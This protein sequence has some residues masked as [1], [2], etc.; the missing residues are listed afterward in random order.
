MSSVFS[1]NSNNYNLLTKTTIPITSLNTGIIY[2]GSYYLIGGN[3]VTYS[4]NSTT[5]ASTPISIS[6]MTSIRNFAWN[7]PSCGIPKIQPLTIACG[8]G[9]NTL[10]YSPDGIYWNGLGKHIFTTRSNKAI[11]NGILWTAVGSGGYW[12]ATSYDG[13]NWLGRDNSCMTEGYDIAWNGVFF[14]AIGS[15]TTS[16]MA[17]SPDGI[18]WT[19]SDALSKIFT[20]TINSIQWT[21][22]IWLA[23][24]SGTNTT[25]TSA[26]GITWQSTTPKNLI[27]TDA[28]NVFSNSTAASSVTA[29]SITSTYLATYVSDNSMNPTT[30]TEWRSNTSLYTAST[31]IY[32]GTTST[33]YNN[34]L[35]AS[36]EWLQLNAQESLK[37]VYYH[38]SWFTDISSSYFTLP[39]EWYLLGSTT[40]TGN[41]NLIDYFNYNRTT[42][43]VN[44]TSNKFVIKLQNIY[45][46]ADAYQYYRV[47]FPSIFPGG[48]QTFT[49]VSEL[50]L[51]YENGNSTNNIN[52]YIKPI[53]T[54]THVLIR[55]WFV[56]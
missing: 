31:G 20:N 52:R 29:S 18:T 53:I 48:S 43:P 42:P 14:I 46:N 7:N 24:G 32:T 49:R 6:G 22:K 13:I 55:Y 2:N 50:D 40:G 9:T 35:S 33:I 5:W 45:S 1:T 51:F 4:T 28:S 3:A 30:S 54:P 10:G 11:W 8:E 27:I 12:V 15:G 36:G 19:R 44:I 21:G 16:N 56:Q 25:A 39:K 17:T 37:I 38:I 23:T 34:T 26:D 47:V 41:W